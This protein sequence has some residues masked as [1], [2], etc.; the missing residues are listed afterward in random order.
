MKPNMARPITVP[1]AHA[2]RDA[3][4]PD[5]QRLRRDHA[6]QLLALHP[7]GAQAEVAPSLEGQDQQPVR[8]S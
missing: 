6:T 8:E 3:D 2:S 4:R 7:D 5:Q 1:S